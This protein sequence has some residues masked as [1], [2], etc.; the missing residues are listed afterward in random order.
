M[1][2]DVLRCSQMFSDDQRC[3]WIFSR[4][5]IDWLI[6]QWKEEKQAVWHTTPSECIF[7]R[8]EEEASDTSKEKLDEGDTLAIAAQHEKHL[9]ARPLQNMSE[10]RWCKPAPPKHDISLQIFHLKDSQ[11]VTGQGQKRHILRMVGVEVV[12]ASPTPTGHRRDLE[13]VKTSEASLVK[14]VRP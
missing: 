12:L 3:F 6:F 13:L 4:Y 2:S 8:V 11:G 7:S 5:S 10:R 9:F 1:C 14:K